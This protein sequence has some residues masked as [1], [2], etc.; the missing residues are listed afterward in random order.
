[1]GRTP[2]TVTVVDKNV[3]LM[4]ES[5]RVEIGMSYRRLSNEA[6]VSL[7]RLHAVLNTERS[8]T[9]GELESI[10][11]VL[12]LV[13]WKVLREAEQGL[14]RLSAV[15]DSPDV[16]SDDLDSLDGVP[17]AALDPGYDPSMEEEPDSP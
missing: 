17:F 5:R 14:G 8:M 2:L 1:M 3:S 6:D 11:E 4:L 16:P 7:S 9:V 13:G 12:G 10:A 15:P